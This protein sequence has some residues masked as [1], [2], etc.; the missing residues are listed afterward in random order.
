MVGGTGRRAHHE[1]VAVCGVVLLVL[2]TGCNG[3]A[4]LS[5]EPTPPEEPDPVTGANVADFVTDRARADL[6]EMYSGGSIDCEAGRHLSA[7]GGHYVL[8]RCDVAKTSDRTVIDAYPSGAYYV[9]TETTR[10]VWRDPESTRYP[11]ESI[12]G[13]NDPDARSGA[14]TVRLYNFGNTSV[15]ISIQLTYLESAKAVQAFEDRYE[16]SPQSSVWQ[17]EP[18]AKPG[19]YR[20]VVSSSDGATA[21]SEWTLSDDEGTSEERALYIYRGPDGML[22]VAPGPIDDFDSIS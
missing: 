21:A 5:S 10:G 19:S 2:M 22:T 4:D 17:I 12:F 6:L 11:P 13:E 20:V 3:I 18:V 16:L 1:A 7:D 14:D 9:D 15:D 8:V